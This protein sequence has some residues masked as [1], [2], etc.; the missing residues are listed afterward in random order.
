MVLNYKLVAYAST[1]YEHR[2]YDGADPAFL[3]RRDDDQYDFTIGLR[4]LPIPK[5]TIKPQLSYIQNN[6]NIDLFEFDRT[7]LS[8]NFR[9]DF[10][11]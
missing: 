4:Y 3:I 6:S 10:N 9:R 8:V 11:W 5:W 1:S 2:L 7:V